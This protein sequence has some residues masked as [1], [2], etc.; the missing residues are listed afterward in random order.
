[1]KLASHRTKHGLECLLALAVAGIVLPAPA[2]AAEKVEEGYLKSDD[3]L[4]IFYQKI[5]RGPQ[6][7]ILPGGLFLFDDFRSLASGRTLIFYDMRNRGRSQ[8][9]EDPAAVTIENDV[10]DLEA[11]RRHFGAERFSAVGYSYLGLMVV[12][13]AMEHPERVKRLVQISA[14][15]LKFGTSYP[16]EL[17]AP[18]WISA[19]D[20]EKVAELRR[21]RAEGF[22]VRE[23]KAY[24]EK[25]WEV[26]R[27][28][29]VGDPAKVERLGR[30]VCAYEN[31]W[32]V[33]F[34][35]HLE[36]HFVGSVQKLDVPRERVR[37]VTVPVLTVHG[38]MDRNAPYGAGREWAA[39]LPNARL[40]TVPGAAHQVWADESRVLGWIDEFLAG[41]WPE[42]TEKIEAGER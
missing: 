26:T 18:D 9:V 42:R 8:R 39:L 21:L 6:A 16:P 13:Y 4:E 3:G 20:P 29:L 17:S 15:P 36:A 10:R 30:G 5:G 11:V 1:M 41:N 14:V 37:Q 24:C 33:N 28:A 19:M 38:T 25:F 12:L 27:V 22:N 23:P 34:D 35:R 40:L 32:P 31:E 7:V 2:Q